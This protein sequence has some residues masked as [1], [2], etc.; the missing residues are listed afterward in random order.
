MTQIAVV[1]V[2]YIETLPVAL[3]INDVMIHDTITPASSAYGSVINM[4]KEAMVNTH[5]VVRSVASADELNYPVLVE[6]G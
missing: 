1:L 4:I 5:R 2:V 6:D 3:S